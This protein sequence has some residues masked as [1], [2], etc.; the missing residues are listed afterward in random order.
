MSVCVRSHS[1]LVLVAGWLTIV[2]FVFQ[3][4]VRGLPP[5]AKAITS[6]E[7]LMTL[8]IPEASLLIGSHLLRCVVSCSVFPVSQF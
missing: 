7:H 8:H 3:L 6:Q 5:T 1:L 2:S 4:L